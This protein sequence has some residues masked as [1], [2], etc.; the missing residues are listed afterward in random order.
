MHTDK[1]YTKADI[2]CQID[3]LNIP[4]GSI[5]L[6]HTAYRLIGKVEGGAK[7]VLD[8]FIEYFTADGGL[9]CVPTHTWANIKELFILDMNDSKT[10]LGAFSDFAAADERGIRSL[11]PSHSMMVF[12]DR[13][14]ALEF[15]KD[16]AYVTSGTA[17]ESCYGKLFT[18]GG[19]VLLI[20][21]PH[22]RNTYL[23]AVDEI[24]GVPNRLA[25]NALDVCIKLKSGE[26]IP[27]K[28]KPH[29]TTFTSDVSLRFHKYETAFR[30]HG[31]ITDGFIGNAP[32]QACNAV[33]MKETMEK[34]FKNSGGKDPLENEL[35]IPTTWYR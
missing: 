14:R 2:L 27:R 32:A 24:L 7:T 22:S 16:D 33:I 1:I 10:C 20:G 18:E 29:R 31:A 25:E 21:V 19:Y 35:L 26:I 34:I 17:P 23:H 12:G 30:Y 9:F 4:K 11:N 13:K 6:A 8:A 5:V 28:I 3:K 15:I